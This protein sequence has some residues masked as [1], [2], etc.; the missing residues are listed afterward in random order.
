[1]GDVK[2]MMISDRPSAGGPSSGSASGSGS[3][4]GVN[5]G[6]YKGVMLCNRPFAGVSGAHML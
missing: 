3:S 6:N 1:M 5:I 2:G 4:P